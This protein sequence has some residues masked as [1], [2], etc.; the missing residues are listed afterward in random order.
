MGIYISFDASCKVKKSEVGRYAKHVFRKAGDGVNHGNELID[1]TKTHL[2]WSINLKKPNGALSDFHQTLRAKLIWFEKE[3]LKYNASERPEG[4]RARRAVNENSVIVRGLVFQP[5]PE[6][7]E[8]LN[9]AEKVLK[10]RAFQK[11]V[12]SWFFKEFG[13]RT[14][15]AGSVH[16]DE[17]NPHYHV[18]M[19]PLTDDMRLSQKDF[20]KSP[21][22]MRNLHKSLRSHM[23]ELGWG[24]EEENKYYDAKRYSEDEYK[25]GAVEIEE[26]RRNKK[27]RKETLDQREAM[28]EE[29]ERELVQQEKD[30]A[31]RL[32]KLEENE[33]SLQELRNSLSVHERELKEREKKVEE[34]IDNAEREFGGLGL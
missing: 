23:N 30:Y 32:A 34:A 5:S 3:R 14:F 13:I 4:K 29:R 16:L 15:L 12:D 25:L 6:I 24:F 17:T 20:F 22:H 11:D 1:S 9:D 18:S 27:R 21:M 28:L 2:N 8:K 33:N 31:A 10:M 7:F 19:I 26:Q